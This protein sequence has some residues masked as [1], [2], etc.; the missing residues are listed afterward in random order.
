MPGNPLT[1]PNW[2]PDLADTVVRLVGSVRDKATNK[3]VVAVRA[4][5]FGVIIGVAGIGAFTLSI[6]LFT[7]LVQRLVN[8]GGWID[9]D[10]AVWVSYLV[11][12]GILVLAGWFCMR[13]R[14][15]RDDTSKA[16]T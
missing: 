5:V 1:D 3:A 11:V 16:R 4:L 8:I 9:A 15:P 14:A 7:K 13:L 12:G 2:A 6:I 10:S